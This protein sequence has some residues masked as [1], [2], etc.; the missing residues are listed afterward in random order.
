M[1]N[2]LLGTPCIGEPHPFRGIPS[3][4]NITSAVPNTCSV[5]VVASYLLLKRQPQPI[6]VTK[7]DGPKHSDRDVIRMLR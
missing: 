6:D 4:N 5:Y 2:P 3:D 1:R 7:K